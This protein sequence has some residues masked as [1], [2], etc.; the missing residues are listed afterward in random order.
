MLRDNLYIFSTERTLNHGTAMMKLKVV[1][2]GGAIVIGDNDRCERRLC[3]E[4]L[5]MKQAILYEFMCV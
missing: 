5:L 2:V 4:W 3:F 1:N